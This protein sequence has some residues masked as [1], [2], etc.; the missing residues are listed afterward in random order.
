MPPQFKKPGRA[1]GTKLGSPRTNVL[2]SIVAI[3]LVTVVK[4]GVNS[5]PVIPFIVAALKS[6]GKV[7]A[8]GAGGGGP[9]GV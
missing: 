8:G 1:K 3:L 6:L 7:G 9:A 4:K 5:S 2:K